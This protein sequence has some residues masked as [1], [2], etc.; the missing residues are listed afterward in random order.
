[1]YQT[2]QSEILYESL[3]SSTNDSTDM[4]ASPCIN[5]RSSSTSE[6]IATYLNEE[7]D[8]SILLFVI[9]NNLQLTIGRRERSMML[10]QVCQ[11]LI[12]MWVLNPLL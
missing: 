1:M 7:K 8:V 6:V 9:V 5:I 11:F 3:I 4:E 10:T 2:T 12:S